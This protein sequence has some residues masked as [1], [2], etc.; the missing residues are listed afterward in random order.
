MPQRPKS[1]PAFEVPVETGLQEAPVGW[2]YREENA[3]DTVRPQRSPAN[4]I[5]MVATGLVLVGVGTVGVL[6]LAAFGLITAPLRIASAIVTRR[7]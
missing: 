6:S 4:P 3:D 2:V 1:R 7:L 5:E